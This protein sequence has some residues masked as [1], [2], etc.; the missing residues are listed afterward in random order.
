M[1]L[2]FA[3]AA[4][5]DADVL[6]L[7]EVFAVGDEAFQR[8]CFGR[9]FEFK[10]RGGTI[11]FVS[12]DAA[13]V[14]RLCERAVLLR[15]GRLESTARRG[16]RSR[17]TGALLAEEVDPAERAA[18]L[19]EWGTRRGARCRRRGCSARRARSASSSS[20]ASRC[21]LRL[22]VE[23]RERRRAAAAAARAPRR[24]A[25][26]SLP[27]RRSRRPRSAG[28]AARGERAAP[29][30]RRALPL[31]DGRFH[32]RLGLSEADGGR[33]LHWLDDALTFLVYPAGE[34]RGWCGSKEAGRSRRN[35]RP[36]ELAHVPGLARADGARARPPVQALHGRR[37]AAPGR[38]ADE[39]H[40][41]VARRRSRSAA[42]SSTTSST[43]RTPSRRSRRP[44][45][46]RTGSR[47]ASGPPRARARRPRR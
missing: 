28:T 10:Q 15:D 8:K 1:R 27:A 46:T 2:G 25:A 3:I 22:R 18:G 12:H 5:L 6:L 9:I 16:R 44:C 42:T 47:C 33:Q 36:D 4:H 35:P 39:D 38:G 13:A 32:L 40:A 11:V 29:L 24:R 26:C 7:D 19:R 23:S 14:E 34:E 20:R 21:A 41:G 30:R 45:A 43:P 31:S 37:G 17:A